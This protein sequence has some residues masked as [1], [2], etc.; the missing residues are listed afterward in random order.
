MTEHVT[1]VGKSGGGVNPPFHDSGVP[2]QSVEQVMPPIGQDR[3]GTRHKGAIHITSVSGI[4]SRAVCGV[5]QRAAVETR[6]V[7]ETQTP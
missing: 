1:L 3:V 6:Q 4:A 7:E 5:A 2:W